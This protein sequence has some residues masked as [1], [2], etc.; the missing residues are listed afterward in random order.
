MSGIG[1]VTMSERD[2]KRVELLARIDDGW[3]SIEAGINVPALSERQV[4]RLLRKYRSGGASA[5]R[6]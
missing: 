1:W 5:V 3:L 2:L 6:H 4:F